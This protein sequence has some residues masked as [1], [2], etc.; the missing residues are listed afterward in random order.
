MGRRKPPEFWDE[1]WRRESRFLASGSAEYR[2]GASFVGVSTISSQYYCEYKAENQYT[3]GEIPTEVKEEGSALHDELVPQKEISPQEF[4]SLVSRREPSFAVLKVWGTV[5]GL[6]VVGIPDHIVWS[7]CRPLWLVELKSTRSDP[8]RLW[9]D[10][11]NQLRI[12][13]LLLELM[14]FDCSR[15][16]LALVRLNAGIIGD[17]DR[18]AWAATVSSALQEGKEKELED[19]FNGGMKVYLLRHDV[20][21]ATEAVLAKAGYWLNERAPTSSSSTGKCRACEYC[22]LCSKS[23]FRG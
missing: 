15:L 4:V 14:G 13:G 19:R 11:E 17:I 10:Q 1:L 18:R 16:K 3:L 9:E 22:D 21:K 5:G 20:R 2:H 8:A 7:D 23:L 6:R 12:Y